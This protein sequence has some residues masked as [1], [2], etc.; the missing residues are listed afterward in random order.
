[1]VMGAHEKVAQYHQ[2]M[3]STLSA[4][5]QA[6][7]RLSAIEQ[8]YIRAGKNLPDDKYP[9]DQMGIKFTLGLNHHYD[10]YKYYGSDGKGRDGRLEV[11]ISNSYGTRS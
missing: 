11:A 10:D 6:Y 2:A 8:A 1:M 3:R 9:E 4:I 5:E 7:I